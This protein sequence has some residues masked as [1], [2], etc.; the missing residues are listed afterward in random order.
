MSYFRE[1]ERPKRHY[2]PSDVEDGSDP[3]DDE[4]ED[5]EPWNQGRPPK[6]SHRHLEIVGNDTNDI[7]DLVFGGKSWLAE[8]TNGLGD[9]PRNKKRRADG[10]SRRWF[11]KKDAGLG[12]TSQV[13]KAVTLRQNGL[14]LSNAEDGLEQEDEDADDMDDLDDGLDTA[15]PV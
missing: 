12:P 1:A 4:T 13:D 6:V 14:E 11:F 9:R 2:P 15:S 5:D 3:D 7:E 8:P 10:N